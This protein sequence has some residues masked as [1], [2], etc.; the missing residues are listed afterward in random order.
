MNQITT[1]LTD[2]TI[3]NNILLIGFILCFA[4]LFMRDSMKP[5]S[6]IDWRDL[7]IDTTTNKISMGKFGQFW[8]IAVSTWVIITLSQVPEAF[9]IFPII[10]PMYLAFIGGTWSY[11]TYLKSKSSDDKKD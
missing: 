6:P 5:K 9:S 2:T 11:S 10:F 4:I 1:L 7:L 3:I 8:G